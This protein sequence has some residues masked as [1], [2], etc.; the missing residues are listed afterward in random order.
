[1]GFLTATAF[2]SEGFLILEDAGPGFVF[3]SAPRYLVFSNT[4][5]SLNQQITLSTDGPLGP[6]LPCFAAGT[7][8]ATDRGEVAVEHLSPGDKVAALHRG[9]FVPITWIGQRHVDCAS[10]RQPASLWPLRVRAHA[11]APG[12]PHRDLFLSPDHAVFVDGVLI[13]IRYLENGRS[14]ARDPRDNLTYFHI[15]LARHDVLLAEGLPCESYLG[16]GNRG[17]FAGTR[18]DAD[19]AQ[20]MEAARAVWETQ[21]CARLHIDGSVVAA[22][23]TRLAAR[24]ATLHAA[25]LDTVTPPGLVLRVG[26]GA[27]AVDHTP[28]RDGNFLRFTL[29]APCQGARLVSGAFVPAERTQGKGDR[30]CLGRPVRRLIADGIEMK[31]DSPALHFGWHAPEPGLR[32]TAGAGTLPRLRH[33]AVE[34]A[35]FPRDGM[36]A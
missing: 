18:R 2:Y 20:A 24:A 32:W 14:I 16:T 6:E 33:L 27:T 8:I 7:R 1:M 30:R 36:A 28:T 3:S 13:P 15:E 26:W 34:L 10:A 5:M 21:A 35:D 12:Q 22:I 4:A 9:G 31:L 11:F 29:P 23:R 25:T 17:D 19:D